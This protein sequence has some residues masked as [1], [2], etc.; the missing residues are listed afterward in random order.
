MNNVR[1]ALLDRLPVGAADRQRLHA[2]LDRP[3]AFE[4]AALNCREVSAPHFYQAKAALIGVDYRDLDHT[5]PDPRLL[6]HLPAPLARRCQAVVLDRTPAG[7]TVGMADPSDMRAVDD[8]ERFLQASVQ[9]V[10]I[11]PRQLQAV[12]PDGDGQIATL[13]QEAEAELGDH[14]RSYELDDIARVGDTDEAALGRLLRS[15]LADAV[16]VGASDLHLEP[17]ADGL[18]LRLRVDGVLRERWLEER[19]LGPAVISRLKLLGGMDIAERRL[20][21]DGRFQIEVEKH[22][23]DV[24]LATLPAASGETLCLRLLDATRQQLRLDQIGL[25]TAQCFELSHVLSQPHGLVLMVGPTGSGKTT[26]VYAALTQLDARA[27]KIITVEDPVEYRLPRL[28][29]IQV[30]SGIGLD[31]ARVLRAALRHDPDVLLVGEMRDSETAEIAMRAALTGH[32]VLSTVHGSSISSALTR[33]EDLQVENYVTAAGLSAVVAQRLM[34]RTCALCAIPAEL[35]APEREWLL[36]VAGRE[37]L[38]WPLA[39]GAG[40]PACGH[41]GYRGRIAAF[42]VL[43]IDDA[44]RTHIRERVGQALPGHGEDAVLNAALRHA[45]AGRTS[46]AE[47]LRVFGSAHALGSDHH[48]LAIA[49]LAPGRSGA[50]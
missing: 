12:L 2:L 17:A 15:L 7:Y 32:V 6:S 11:S 35:T 19:N 4:T 14:A 47:L 1:A 34:R 9:P 10:L 25:D 18:R 29:Q 22:T 20:P 27:R 5:L 26:S 41:T 16:E 37:A 50:A 38:D 33:L 21:Q 13:A 46:I 3:E 43:R 36:A 24:R 23:V 49:E 40:C 8:L 48:A 42:D 31:F 39:V 44:V 30:K 45:Q 28:T